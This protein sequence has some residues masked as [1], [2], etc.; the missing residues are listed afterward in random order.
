MIH[1]KV[2]ETFMARTDPR[3]HFLFC[4]TPSSTLLLT[5]ALTG[6]RAA[7]KYPLN[8]EHNKLLSLEP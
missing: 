6:F 7:F 8:K 2:D 4:C 3:N 5:L 1:K